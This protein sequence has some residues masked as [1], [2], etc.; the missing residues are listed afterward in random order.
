MNISAVKMPVIITM[1]RAVIP[2]IAIIICRLFASQ[3]QLAKAKSGKRIHTNASP[4][5]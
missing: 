2:I 4:S 5:E 3:K 1:P